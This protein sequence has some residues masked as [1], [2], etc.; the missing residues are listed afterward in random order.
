[1]FGGFVQYPAIFE[2][3]MTSARPPDG[4]VEFAEVIQ[5]DDG[6]WQINVRLSWRP[7][8]MF[9][10]NKY[11]IRDIRLYSKCATALAHIATT[12]GYWG[13]II[14]RPNRE[15]GTKSHF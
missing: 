12:Y 9:T 15:V 4:Q 6:K 5:R 1:M 8:I 2:R 13:E 14:V 10:I 3:E 7:G 11:D